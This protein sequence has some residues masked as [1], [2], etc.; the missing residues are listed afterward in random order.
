MQIDILVAQTA[1][2]KLKGQLWYLSEDLVALALFSDHLLVEEKLSLI[3][4]MKLPEKKK[5]LRRLD[6]TKIKTFMNKTLSDFA[7]SR[8]YNLFSAL[9][10]TCDFLDTNPQTW[11]SRADYMHAKEKVSAI[12]VVNDCAE[13]AVKLAT[14]YNTILTH[15]E[16][17]RQLI[18]QVVE[19]HRQ[20]FK[21]PHK[22]NF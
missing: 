18:F 12:K 14:D 20:L 10:V 11:D 21:L 5:D 19:H 4:A 16:D 13:R 17:Q 2:L 7:S 8:S 6:G 1:F 3:K 9:K 22:K 15:D